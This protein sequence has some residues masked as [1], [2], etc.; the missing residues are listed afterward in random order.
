M[1]SVRPGTGWFDV[2]AIGHRS[3]GTGAVDAATRLGVD[4]DIPENI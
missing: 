2:A 1:S 4:I 3:L